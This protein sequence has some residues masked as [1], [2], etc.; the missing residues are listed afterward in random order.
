MGRVILG[1]LLLE[2]LA[3]WSEHVR[4]DRLRH[5]YI[6]SMAK[7]VGYRRLRAFYRDLENR[8]PDLRIPASFWAQ[9]E[10]D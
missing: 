7:A 2:A 10:R 4:R 6:T 3:F 1:L 8:D 9:F 5:D